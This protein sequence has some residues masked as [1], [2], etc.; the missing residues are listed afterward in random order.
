MAKECSICDK[1]LGFLRENDIIRWNRLRFLLVAAGLD[2]I[3][4]HDDLEHAH[5]EPAPGHD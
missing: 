3:N 5:R 4:S 1:K 2:D